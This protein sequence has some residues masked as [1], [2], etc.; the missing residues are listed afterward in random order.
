VNAPQPP[1]RSGDRR[2]DEEELAVS[3][4]RRDMPLVPASSIAGRALVSVIAIMT[5]LSCL[6]A[7]GAM[8]VASASQ[9]WRSQISREVTIQIKPDAGREIDAQVE[10]AAAT[11]RAAPGVANVQVFSKQDSERLLEPWLGAGLDLSELPIPRLIVV[12]MQ[13]R[14]EPDLS[15]LRSALATQAPGASL[16]D[17]RLWLA[18]LDTMADAIVLFALALFLLMI[19]AM[20]LAIG[21]AKSSK[22]CISSAPPIVTFPV[23]SRAISCAWVCEAGF[24]AGPARPCSFSLRPRSRPGGRIPPAARKLSRCSAPL[25]WA[26]KAMW[27]FSRW[28]SQLEC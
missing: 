11:A 8:L 18:R 24:S 20:M 17:H 15:A 21:F 13:D 1:D 19:S 27:R 23:N 6:T 14:V 22:C 26:S 12:R 16:D 10:K 28:R 5:F 9:G 25:R 4:L 3:R 2:Q 7:G